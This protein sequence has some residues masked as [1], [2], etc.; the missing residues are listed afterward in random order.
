MQQF[1]SWQLNKGALSLR[2]VMPKAIQNGWLLLHLA[3][4]DEMQAQI[5]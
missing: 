4:L 2:K 5:L 1:N 3:I